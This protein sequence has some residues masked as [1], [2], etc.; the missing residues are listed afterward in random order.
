[1]ITRQP[2]QFVVRTAFIYSLYTR[3]TV[4]VNSLFEVL[5][6]THI[7]QNRY[8]FIIYGADDA[9]TKTLQYFEI[10][11]DEKLSFKFFILAIKRKFIYYC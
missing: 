5:A 1:V 9:K 6:D 7:N 3:Q 4:F 2:F 8:Y 11:V 10:I